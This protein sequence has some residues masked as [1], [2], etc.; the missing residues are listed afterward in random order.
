[1]RKMFRLFQVIRTCE[2]YRIKK[3]KEKRTKELEKRKKK[4]EK[5][6]LIDSEASKE[7]KPEEKTQ[8]ASAGAADKKKHF[9][10]MRKKE[11]AASALKLMRKAFFSFSGYTILCLILLTLG[12]ADGVA[13]PEADVL[14][15]QFKYLVLFTSLLILLQTFPTT[16]TALYKET[17]LL[18]YATLPLKPM[19]LVLP[20]IIRLLGPAYR[21]MAGMLL[22][23]WAGYSIAATING[24]IC[25]T[26]TEAVFSAI[27]F[28]PWLLVCISAMGIIVGHI[29]TRVLVSERF[30]QRVVIPAAVGLALV[31]LLI[32]LD[33]LLD[34]A[35]FLNLF[36]ML[37][38][39]FSYN[40]VFRWMIEGQVFL[41]FLILIL[42]SVIAGLLLRGVIDLFYRKS[43][44][45]R[46]DLAEASKPGETFNTALKEHSVFRAL[47]LRELRTV[48]GMEIFSLP[49][50]VATLLLP[51][52]LLILTCGA[53]LL[54]MRYMTAEVKAAK[55]VVGFLLRMV[56]PLSLVPALTN[57][58]AGGAYSRDAHSMEALLLM[59]I[60]LDLQMHAKVLSAFII[61]A[62]GSFLYVVAGAIWLAVRKV[63]PVWGIFPAVLLNLLLLY[64]A[65]QLQ[66][67]RDIHKMNLTWK[68]PKE[69]VKG[70]GLLSGLLILLF[71]F[72]FPMM[73]GIFL[74]GIKLSGAVCMA[75]IF[76]FAIALP[77]MSYFYLFIQGTYRL[78]E[79][80]KEKDEKKAG[81]SGVKGK[82][83]DWLKVKKKGFFPNFRRK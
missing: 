74:E 69:L 72:I 76:F 73:A 70:R 13:R 20:K 82:A 16:N 28:V 44:L 53:E 3:D 79:L 36:R 66:V 54:L 39:A 48:R 64:W 9:W 59:P 41:P 22:P 52:L 55:V 8:T 50:F 25:G 43:L 17:N 56:V 81:I 67:M 77:V 46:Y 83:K 68:K 19:E 4:V 31:C 35:I 29:Y 18:L 23:L 60:D 62:R 71:G 51:V 63:I 47:I 58:A 57:R 30:L 45:Q 37:L 27:L 26:L 11:K 42:F 6:L 38:D 7:K 21:V 49:I 34:V 33:L 75:W 15:R 65:A 10:R 2:K 1:M 24:S 12:V 40:F 61:C 80:S 14:I 78:R 32:L 5:I